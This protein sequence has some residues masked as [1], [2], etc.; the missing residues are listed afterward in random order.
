MHQ[1]NHYWKNQNF[2]GLPYKYFYVLNMQGKGW[3]KGLV[4][5]F[6]SFLGVGGEGEAFPRRL[7]PVSSNISW[8]RTGSSHTPQT[9][10]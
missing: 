8:A 10:Y 4:L 9:S 2:V 1:K 5:I 7:Q 6:L 3:K